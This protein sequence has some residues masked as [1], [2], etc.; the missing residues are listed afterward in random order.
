[1]FFT[2]GGRRRL[3]LLVGICVQIVRKSLFSIEHEPQLSPE[4]SKTTTVLKEV[5][6]SNIE[7]V[8][9][10]RFELNILFSFYKTSSVKAGL[11]LKELA[12]NTT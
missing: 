2:I 10:Y 3:S 5:A 11:I 8:E 4:I 6:N 9:L 1:M 12:L 7:V